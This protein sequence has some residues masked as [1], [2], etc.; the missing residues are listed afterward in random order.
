M[1]VML[2]RPLVC[3]CAWV[4]RCGVSGGGRV[5]RAGGGEEEEGGL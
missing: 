2:V 1:I 3:S 4:G 5:G